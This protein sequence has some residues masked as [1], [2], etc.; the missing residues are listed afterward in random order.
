MNGFK[1]H[2][3]YTPTPYCMRHPMAFRLDSLQIILAAT[4]LETIRRHGR[5]QS[6]A[7]LRRIPFA[8]ALE[9]ATCS[10]MCTAPGLLS[11]FGKLA[12]SSSAKN[13]M[14]HGNALVDRRCHIL[15]STSSTEETCFL[16]L[17]SAASLKSQRQTAR[18]KS[19]RRRPLSACCG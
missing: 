7:L 6:G 14:T 5:P 15:R 16:L 3:V 2:A 9:L 13:D 8:L 11:C 10:M 1:F 18:A 4:L 17:G 12:V 19:K